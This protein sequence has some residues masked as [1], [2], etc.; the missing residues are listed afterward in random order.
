MTTSTQ[1]S[2]FTAEESQWSSGGGNS[3]GSANTSLTSSASFAMDS[4]AESSQGSTAGELSNQHQH[5]HQL[6]QHIEEPKR[7]YSSCALSLSS[8]TDMMI[9]F[10]RKPYR[11]FRSNEEYLI[12]MKEDL[13][14]WLNTLYTLDITAD[15]FLN[16]LETGVILCRHAN[17][18][19]RTA[20]EWKE[21]NADF[22]AL[23]NLVLTVVDLHRDVPVKVNAAP[24][25]FQARDN[26]ANF[27]DWCRR[28]HIKECL[29]FETEDLVARKNEIN[30][31]LC[32]L[33]VAR[34]GAKFGLLA[35]T[36]VQFE[37]EIDQEL[38]KDQQESMTK[39][40]LLP[41]TDVSALLGDSELIFDDTPQPQITNNDLESLHEKVVNLLSRCTCPVQFYLEHLS[42]GKY[43]IGDTRTLIFV[44]ILRNHVMV[45]VG[46]GWDTLEH[47][48]EK[49]DPCRCRFAHRSTSAA[50]I[51][52]NSGQVKNPQ[53]QVT[54]E[55]P[56]N[57]CSQPRR[58]VVSV[59]SSP[60][61]TRRALGRAGA[62]TPSSTSS[63]DLSTIR[64]SS[65]SS[66]DSATSMCSGSLASAS[67][68]D[69]LV[70]SEHSSLSSSNSLGSYQAPTVLPD[71]NNNIKDLE[72]ANNVANTNGSKAPA[73][74][75]PKPSP[76]KRV[77]ATPDQSSRIPKSKIGSGSSSSISMRTGMNSCYSANSSR[78]SSSLTSA[79]KLKSTSTLA[80]PQL[81]SSTTKIPC[82]DATN[83]PRHSLSSRYSS[84]N[85]YLAVA[86]EASDGKHASKRLFPVTGAS[87]P[88]KQRSRVNGMNG[89]LN[90]RTK[91]KSSL[92]LNVGNENFF[93]LSSIDKSNHSES[94]QSVPN[95][96]PKTPHQQPQQQ[97]QQNRRQHSSSSL[98]RV[99]KSAH[100]SPYLKRRE[101][102]ISPTTS[103]GVMGKPSSGCSAGAGSAVSKIAPPSKLD[104]A[105]RFQ[106][107][108]TSLNSTASTASGSTNSSS[109]SLHT[110]VPSAETST[111][112]QQ[113]QTLPKVTSAIA[114]AVGG[115]SFLEP[116]KPFMS[117]DTTPSTLVEVC[118]WLER[119][120]LASS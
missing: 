3:C 88:A 8:D 5:Q 105:K 13:A 74:P 19:L 70:S 114:G 9:G 57:S 91:Q 66:N 50:R 32:L 120:H 17:S 43:R 108:A 34:Y 94:Q 64:R 42:E 11:P 7:S 107:S 117:T 104:S 96:T 119:N 63:V 72:T 29:L 65:T 2:H 49:H 24:G 15:N 81:S 86:E 101:L 6:Q 89:N 113:Q 77:L 55:R 61:A 41:P 92:E 62:I 16:R 1:P 38:E 78:S 39:R 93:S 31:V 14:E 106:G 69:S 30:F 27:I 95:K 47:Y 10:E 79:H 73:I 4:L 60:S 80:I 102:T 109:S 28:I 54:F 90:N 68:A 44:R 75:H 53:M 52:F 33:E 71:R 23:T 87:A 67:H 59:N 83:K 21:H 20:R 110:S 84:H 98:P 35:P 26:V 103:N 85:I 58:S 112:L 12:A 25:T 45:R 111:D 115:S 82:L 22:S 116:K 76:K 18:V 97:Q 51:T 118:S 37:Q 36:L 100:N 46:G 99:S 48:L 56:E 40:T